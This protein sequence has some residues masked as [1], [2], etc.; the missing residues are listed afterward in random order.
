M[1]SQHTAG[2][3]PPW[4]DAD[5]F[6]F[7]SRFLDFFSSSSPAFIAQFAAS[8]GV[9]CVLGVPCTGIDLNTDLSG[10]AGGTFSSTNQILWTADVA[11]TNT[12]IV[13]VHTYDP[14]S[15]T[16]SAPNTLTAAGTGQVFVTDAGT[17]GSVPL[18]IVPPQP[19]ITSITPS[20]VAAG[21]GAFSVTVFGSGFTR[22]SI[23]A[24]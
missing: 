18:T 14:V 19:S 16:S 8:P 6:P 2:S 21:G 13:A 4:V 12:N 7:E 1:S 20:S 23:P 22:G 15:L 11:S 24:K 17:S 9:A 5:L 3:R 10:A